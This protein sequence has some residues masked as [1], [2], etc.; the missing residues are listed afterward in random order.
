MQKKP[1]KG[2]EYLKKQKGAV[3]AHRRRFGRNS[4]EYR[5]D[6]VITILHLTSRKKEIITGAL[7]L[8]VDWGLV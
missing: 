1:K 3:S 5:N 6:L 4:L 8:F 2:V 7:S